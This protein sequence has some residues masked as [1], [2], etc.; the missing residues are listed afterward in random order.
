LPDRMHLAVLAVAMALRNVADV[1]S[2]S[3]LPAA[4]HLLPKQIT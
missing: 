2:L 3:V 4:E 1:G